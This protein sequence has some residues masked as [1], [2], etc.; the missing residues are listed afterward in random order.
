MSARDFG[1]AKVKAE[2]IELREEFKNEENES[3]MEEEVES[4]VRNKVFNEFNLVHDKNL[5][6]ILHFTPQVHALGD[7]LNRIFEL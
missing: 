3:M 6:H 1:L 5:I 4:V 2:G 7:L